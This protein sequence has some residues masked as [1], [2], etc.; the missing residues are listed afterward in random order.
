VADF[1]R[2]RDMEPEEW[3]TSFGPHFRATSLA[4]LGRLEEALANCALIRDDHWMPAHSGLP[5]GNK[6][7]FIAEIRRRAA[8]ARKR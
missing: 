2:A 1:T 6:E 8:A 5:G 7:Q 3:L 4:H